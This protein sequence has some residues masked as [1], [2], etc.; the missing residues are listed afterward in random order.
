LNAL[1]GRRP[2]PEDAGIW[3]LDSRLDALGVDFAP[4]P[5]FP[6]FKDDQDRPR[7]AQR[8]L[9]AEYRGLAGSGAPGSPDGP[10][11]RELASTLYQE[12]D[13]MLPDPLP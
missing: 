4:P 10:A 3:P 12:A 9:V 1:A 8:A 2:L 5:A 11:L 7:R 13:W 6:A